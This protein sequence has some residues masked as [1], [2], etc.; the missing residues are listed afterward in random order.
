MIRVRRSPIDSFVEDINFV[1]DNFAKLLGRNGQ[2]VAVPSV[3]VWQDSEAVFAELDL[4]GVNPADLDV[5][6]TDG[7]VLTIQGERKTG[8]VEKEAWV[9][10]E[11]GHGKFARTVE[12]PFPV[13][14][15]KVEAKYEAG[16]LRV[17]LPKSEA[18]KPRKIAVK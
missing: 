7:N 14:A 4:P 8:E 16:V 5:T 15:S 9:R 3:D 17:T 11:R 12:L 10:R 1:Q 13:D 2:S 18:A 6:V